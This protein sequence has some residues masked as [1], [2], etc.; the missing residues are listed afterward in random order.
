ML[1]MEDAALHQ[2]GPTI[3]PGLLFVRSS[4]DQFPNT[5]IARIV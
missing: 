4:D 2:Y 5:L 3:V 1:V